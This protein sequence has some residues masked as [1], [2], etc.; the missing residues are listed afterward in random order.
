MSGQEEVV[1]TAMVDQT[2]FEEV[3]REWKAGHL[4]ALQ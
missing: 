1:G 3:Q 2:F 4:Q